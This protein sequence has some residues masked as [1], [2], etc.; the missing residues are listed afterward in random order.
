MALNPPVYLTCR[1]RVSGLHGMVE[2]LEA[3]GCER[4]VFIDNDSTY[5]PLL[6]Y[7]DSSPHELIRLT[8]NLGARAL[9]KADLA[10]SE[11]YVLSDPDLELAG[12]PLDAV[13]HLAELMAHHGHAKAGLGLRLDDVPANMPSLPWERRLLAPE[14][15]DFWAGEIAPGVYD[16]LIDTT[17]AL[18]AAG[19]GFQYEA[20]RT[21]A[22]YLAR[23][24]PWYM[25]EPTEEYAYYLARAIT[26]A[27]GTTTQFVDQAA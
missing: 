13:D 25:T 8:E 15:G 12:V 17:F 16:S 4:I 5:E 20:L 21:G 9:W 1:D 27:D 7:Y 2:W 11:P 6:D 10:P 26:G 24:T 22:P 23:H 18:H 19:T 3:A 14:P